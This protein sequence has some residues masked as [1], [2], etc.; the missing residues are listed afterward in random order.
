MFFFHC[1]AH[2]TPLAVATAT[3]MA[4]R[5]KMILLKLG[6]GPPGRTDKGEQQQ[7]QCMSSHSNST[8]NTARLTT[9]VARTEAVRTKGNRGTDAG[10]VAPLHSDICPCEPATSCNLA[11]GRGYGC[12]FSEITGGCPIR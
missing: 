2:S 8:S 4:D 11:H 9:A 12:Q 3:F 7:Q 5:G 1:F 6:A 10:D